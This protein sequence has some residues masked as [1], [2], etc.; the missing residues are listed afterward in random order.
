[1]VTDIRRVT[2]EDAEAVLMLW[3]TAEATE[4]VTDTLDEVRRVATRENVAFLVA[5]IEGQIVGSLMRTFNGWRGNIYRLAVHPVHRRKGIARALVS[6][7][8]N[9]FLQWGVKRVTALVEKDHPWAVEFWKSAQY[10][11]D[12]R[13]ARYVRNLDERRRPLK[14]D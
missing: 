2:S 14:G 8:E 1:M 6:E 5:V 4:S 3:K 12:A 10:V 11:K 9:A 7:V 13:M